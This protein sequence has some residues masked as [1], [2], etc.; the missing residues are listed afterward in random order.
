[1][2]GPTKGLNA[3]DKH[4][5]LIARS[6][7]YL[8]EKFVTLG[9]KFRIKVTCLEIYHEHVY[10][11][12]TEENNRTSLPVREHTTEGFFLDGCKYI[13]CATYEQACVQLN[14][15]LKTRQVGGHELNSRSSRSHCITEIYI[16]LFQHT[17]RS[18]VNSV[19]G[20]APS[21]APYISMNGT[22]NYVP[23]HMVVTPGEEQP[24]LRGKV[25]LVDLAG[26][27]RLKNTNSTGKVL[28]EAGFINRSLY[29]LGKVIAGLVRTNGD[30]NSKD[31]PYRD[32]KLTK[33]L[34]QCLSGQSRTLL[35]A[36]VSEAKGSQQETL[37]TLKFSM[38]CARIRNKPVKFLDPQEKLILDLKSEIKRLRVENCELRNHLVTAP[39]STSLSLDG[40]D[41]GGGYF[42]ADGGS[43]RPVMARARSVGGVGGLPSPI[44]KV[45]V[46]PVLGGVGSG[47]SHNPYKKPTAKGKKSD[48]KKLKKEKL[49][50]YQKSLLAQYPQLHKMLA[51]VAV[52]GNSH[53]AQLIAGEVA[54]QLQQPQKNENEKEL[55]NGSPRQGRIRPKYKSVLGQQGNPN[56]T[57]SAPSSSSQDQITKKAHHKPSSSSPIHHHQQ[58]PT[59]PAPPTAHEQLELL[60]EIIHRKAQGPQIFKEATSPI[61][62]MRDTRLKEYHPAE[63]YTK[64]MEAKKLYM[65]AAAIA[66]AEEQSMK[67]RDKKEG[68]R[69][70]SINPHEQEATAG[71]KYDKEIASTQDNEDSPPH[72]HSGAQ[73][74][75]QG[76]QQAMGHGGKGNKKPPLSKG[77]NNGAR[78]QQQPPSKP[79]KISPYLAHLQPKQPVKKKDSS[80]TEEASKSIAVSTSQPNQDNNAGRKLKKDKKTMAVEDEMSNEDIEDLLNGFLPPI[81]HT[82]NNVKSNH[83]SNNSQQPPTKKAAPSQQP[84]QKQ[85]ANSQPQSS[86]QATNSKDQNLPNIP[87]N[88]K[89][90]NKKTVTYAPSA[91]SENNN[92]NKKRVTN[93]KVEYYTTPIFENIEKELEALENAFTITHSQSF[94]EDD[95][96]ESNIPRKDKNGIEVENGDDDDDLFSASES[97]KTR[98]CVVYL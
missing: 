66:A 46:R 57:D 6:L 18:S 63:N 97:G 85:A 53:Q 3:H 45:A 60:D 62:L 88:K 72:A 30:I 19:A 9:A 1:M 37:R 65:L 69:F 87:I 15:A 22:S 34:I 28:Q 40:V 92:A 76:K 78:K 90:G 26:S 17:P 8:Y 73:Q 75:Q 33:L 14:S 68:I 89:T 83:Q 31:V 25:S 86:S 95:D 79:N 52:N 5:G 21:S 43:P 20:S 80:P 58:S 91:V 10:D 56:N 29:V 59:V 81:Q 49:S 94:V 13:E 67:E 71:G 42:G 82:N 11:L 48:E 39:S 44:K 96:D 47:G 27:E 70:P 41:M 7:S 32:S 55:K 61:P 64:S 50:N 16:E 24:M 2:L 35:L 74:L 77:N 23:G 36:C 93:E 51:H 38:S 54:Q 12:F 84:P 98:N 4:I